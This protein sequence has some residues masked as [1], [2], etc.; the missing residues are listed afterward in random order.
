MNFCEITLGHP[1]LSFAQITFGNTFLSGVSISKAASHRLVLEMTPNSLDILWLEHGFLSL[2]CLEA[3]LRPLPAKHVLSDLA[4]IWDI[5]GLVEQASISCDTSSWH[6]TAL[7]SAIGLWQ[8]DR[9]HFIQVNKRFLRLL[10]L[11]KLSFVGLHD[12]TNM[13]EAWQRD[14]LAAVHCDHY[15]IFLFSQIGGFCSIL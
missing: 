6:V 5:R 1:I 10:R 11:L 3:T 13:L 12:T 15:L 8:A 4:L 2:L 9:I 14:G 7:G